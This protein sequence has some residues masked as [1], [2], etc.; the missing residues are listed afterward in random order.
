[1]EKLLY[2]APRSEGWMFLDRSNALLFCEF[3]L[4]FRSGLSVFASMK[5]WNGD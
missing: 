5:L 2:Q 4:G 3:C 1:M